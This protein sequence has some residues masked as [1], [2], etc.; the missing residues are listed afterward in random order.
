M[1]RYLL[2][3]SLLSLAVLMCSCQAKKEEAQNI[4]EPEAVS[5]VDTMSMTQDTTVVPAD[6]VEALEIH[7]EGHA[8]E[9]KT[10]VKLPPK[11]S[12]K[13]PSMAALIRRLLIVSSARSKSGNEM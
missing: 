7:Q 6:T 5:E 12:K 10:Q 3:I 1:R 11:L 4:E 2:L 8:I 13:H 9:K